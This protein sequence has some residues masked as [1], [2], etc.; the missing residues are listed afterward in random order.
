M[1]SSTKPVVLDQPSNWES[2]LY[3]IKTIAD[4][5]D[6][7]KYID[8]DLDTEP[9]I[10]QRPRKPS[11]RDVDPGKISILDLDGEEKETYK[12]LMTE[13]REDLAIAKQVLDTIQAV[14]S[15]I[16]TTVST[17][18]IVY[19]KDK[20]SVYQILTALKKRLAPT[21]Y[22]R[23]LELACKYNK[24]KTYSK[25]ENVEK[26]LKDWEIVFTDGRKLKI[27]EVADDRSLFDF[28]H[29][30]SVI[31][32]GYASS[33]EY[34]INQKIKNSENLPDLYDLVEDFRNHLRRTEALK[35]SP[36]HSAFAATL[37]GESQDGKSQ[38][39]N[40]QEGEKP[41]LCGGKHGNKT[42]WEKCHYITPKCRPSGW[43]GKPE[44]FEKINKVLKTWEDGKIKWFIRRF[45]YDGLNDFKASA[46]E[47]KE[48][49]DNDSSKSQ[50]I[51]T[52]I[53]YSSYNLSSSND[54]KL[55]N[56]WTLDNASDIHVCNDFKRSNFCKTRDASLNDKLYAGKT[57][58]VIEAFGTVTVNVETLNGRREIE[59]T[60]VA[61]APGFITNLVSLYLLNLKGVH[62]NS[63]NPQCLTRYGTA[64]CN[65]E[66]IDNHWV[67]EQNAGYSAF[68]SR[69]SVASRKATFTGSQMHR[70]LGHASPEV[71]SH[72]EAAGTDI[73]IDNSTPAPST[74]NCETCSLSKATEIVSRRSEVEEPE[75]GIPFDR[76]TWDMI[77]MNT[78]YNGDRYVSHFQCRQ[79]L[80]NMV[81]THPKK[82]DAFKFFEK[83]LNFI[84]I[85]YNGK[86]RYIRLDGETSLGNAFETLVIKKG[87][88][89]E[90]TAPDTP[91][92][93]SSSERSG[94]VL[95]TK[96]R[97][98]R[99]EAK[100]PANLWPEI[101]KAAGYISNRSPVR[102]LKWKTPFEAV[103]KT[104]PR[105]AH[106]HVYGCRAYPLDHH[107]PKK[108]KLN[109]RAHIGYLVGYDSTNIYRIWIPS[110]K[111]VIRTRDVTLNNNLL[112]NLTDLDIGDILKEQ[113]DQLIE[114]LEL[115]EIQVM[116][117]D[118][119]EDLLD[120]IKDIEKPLEEQQRQ[121]N[122][123]LLTPSPTPNANPM[124][125]ASNSNDT[126]TTALPAA[127][128]NRASRGNE[129]SGD[130]N[131]Q[132]IVEGSR[133]RTRR[134]AYTTALG[135]IEELA[136][137]YTSFCTAS[138][139]VISKPLHRDALPP[140]PKSWKQM[141]K[142]QHSTE[143]KKAA[144]KEFKTLLQKGTFKYIEKSTIND[145]APLIPL[146]WVFTYKFDQ[147]GFL[148]K[149]KARLVARGDLQYTAEDTY[150]ATLAAQTFR[151]VTA[152]I[153]AFDL[154]T[155][156]YD[157]V[158]AFANAMLPNPI[159][160]YT[161]EGY[162][163]L[164][165]ILW[166]EKALYGLKTSPILWYKDFTST[167][168]DLGLNPI[169]DTNCL[170]VNEWLILIFYVDDILAV[171]APKYQE[172]MDEFESRLMNKYEVRK[173][174]E[175][176][177]FLGIR[178]VRN[179]PQR[180]LWL[181]QD[182]YIDKMA[183]KY[184]ITVKDKPPK[185]PLPLTEL[186]PYDG[187]ATAQQIY[188]YQQRV[189]SVNFSAVFTRPDISKAVSKLSE[190]LQNPSPNHK[191]AVDQSLEY[192]LGT[193][194]WAIEFDGNQKDKRIFIALSDSAFA[195]DT[196]TR[197]SS[198]G[199]SFSLFGGIIHYKAVKGTT[200]TTSSTEAELLALSLAAKDF[201]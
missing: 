119:S 51:G 62:W 148:I 149:H 110:R 50:Q 48:S 128:G 104:K 47:S 93:N 97:T 198:Y 182:S 151:A 135:K 166:V 77:E 14:R 90:R 160:C 109:A 188:A 121:D 200:V 144:D 84:E 152:I 73:T 58:Y 146:M 91:A 63:E 70:V 83:S 31:D 21:D 115:P 88:K 163:R 67:F 41:C 139:A 180:K 156:Q 201:I 82:S 56:A 78:A 65:L 96:S 19:I 133:N 129:I 122:S 9:E 80:F 106:M 175:A 123:Q 153:A 45:K 194:Y 181:V 32:S 8:P 33:Q 100:L 164:G 147:D 42:R 126:T 81:F 4:S 99:I 46:E 39:G 54:F 60:N 38:D 3:V 150:A 170:F 172:R 161:A 20:T 2:W 34:F 53:T 179:R 186:V 173:L 15:H 140:V 37:N 5:G 17:T 169:S 108:D 44:T 165:F 57:S 125:S 16:V 158:N 137:Y 98:M 116:E 35:M 168:E 141:L 174:G 102:K 195:D 43:K 75:N 101:V 134:S 145:Q 118:E 199:F 25:R 113:A 87:I 120:T 72:V 131:V 23:K 66:R 124:P 28:T 12:L 64:F 136:G 74:I 52:F 92:Q 105:F 11:V 111:K 187:T 132:N 190:F 86:V 192:L 130:F 185:T 127:P 85:Q 171:Y 154:E 155:R 13:Y 103:T 10:P 189:G 61:L 27:P 89:A 159:A 107:I 71:I 143:F 18:N 7:W 68:A 26:W 193:K 24:L 69:K 55:Y 114:T 196:M 22:A 177:H 6:I 76:T 79:Y 117:D 162:E 191:A 138:K 183:G 197:N 59:L 176:E 178:I 40:S 29:A 112:Y 30:I 1:T 36:S 95:I 94:R 49:K 157:A 142:H 184:N 167:L